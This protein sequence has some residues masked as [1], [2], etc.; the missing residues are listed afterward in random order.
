MRRAEITEKLQRAIALAQAGQRSDARRLLEEVVAAD[1]Q[2]ALA[3]MWLATV[4]DDR[5]ERVR[6]LTRALE[7]EPGN[8][9]AQEAYQQLTGQVYAPPPSPPSRTG[10]RRALLGDAPLGLGSYLILLLVG[11]AAVVVIA[12]AAGARDDEKRAD[13]PPTP[14]FVLPLGHRWPAPVANAQRHTLAHAHARPVA[15]SAVGCAATH[16]DA[17]ADGYAVTNPD[18]CA[19]GDEHPHGEPDAGAGAAQRH[20]HTVLA[21]QHAHAQPHRPAC[22]GNICGDSYAGANSHA[23]SHAD[24]KALADREEFCHCATGRR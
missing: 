14:R 22:N 13:L 9:A 8:R 12:L 20:L 21:D 15:H 16:L 17:G 23:D 11:A 1:P 2:Q 24:G 5:D 6:C 10:W 3:W 7:L 19:D 4:A 18:A